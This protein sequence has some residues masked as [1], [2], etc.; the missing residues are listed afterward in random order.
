MGKKFSNLTLKEI[1]KIINKVFNPKILNI[2]EFS[3]IFLFLIES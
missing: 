2:N 3:L 1:K